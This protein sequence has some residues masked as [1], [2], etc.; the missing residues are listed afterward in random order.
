MINL[1]FKSIS[2]FCCSILW[3]A[4]G[5]DEFPLSFRR[6]GVPGVIAINTALSGNWWGLLSFPLM[7]GAIS[8][9]YGV[10]SVLIRIFNGNKHLARGTCGIAY[11]LAALPILWGNWWA[12]GFHLWILPLGVA[13]A[14]TQKFKG[15]KDITE[16]GF[17]GAIFSIMPLFG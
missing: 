5:S 7:A 1:V 12:F 13:L 10:N 16:E 17:I 4:G 14:G 15:Q 6:M 2:V 8:I 3:R 9:G 11:A